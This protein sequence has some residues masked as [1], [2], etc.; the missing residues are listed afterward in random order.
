[1]CPLSSF[2]HSLASQHNT[3]PQPAAY[4][5][6]KFENTFENLQS[7]TVLYNRAHTRD[8][9]AAVSYAIASDNIAQTAHKSLTARTV[10]LLPLIYHRAFRAIKS[11]DREKSF[12]ALTLSTVLNRISN[13]ILDFE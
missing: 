3:I 11:F 6:L 12:K 4:I 9:S 1:M 2:H 10:R 7:P 13:D 5:Q 8:V